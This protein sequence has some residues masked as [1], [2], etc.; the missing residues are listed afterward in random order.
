MLQ[1]CSVFQDRE[2]PAPQTNNSLCSVDPEFE[3]ITVSQDDPSL[4]A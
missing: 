4:V 3:T 2:N 1:S